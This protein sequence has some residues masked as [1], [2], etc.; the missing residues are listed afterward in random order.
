VK[1]SEKDLIRRY[2]E[3]ENQRVQQESRTNQ[4]WE[5]V[6]IDYA[7]AW[8]DD[9]GSEIYPGAKRDLD[10]TSA[11]STLY[12]V[13]KDL[14]MQR[15]EQGTYTYRVPG[16][17]RMAVADALAAILRHRKIQP[18]SGKV[19]QL[20]RTLAK[21]KRKK[22]LAGSG[23]MEEETSIPK[24]KSHHET[25]AEVIAERKRFQSERGK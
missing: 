17:Q 4:E 2:Q 1:K 18:Q 13:A 8:V 10:I 24:S 11:D 9:K 19:K 15:D 5:K 21:E 23:S 22:S 25:L 7:N 12:R 6:R 20:E 14:Y 16:G 3:V